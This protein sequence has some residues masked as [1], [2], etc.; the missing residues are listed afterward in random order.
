MLSL[1]STL[2]SRE[3]LQ[4]N[5]GES[6][7]HQGTHQNKDNFS[8][9]HV[10]GSHFDSVNIELPL[11]SPKAPGFSTYERES[12]GSVDEKFSEPFS[13][14]ASS[15]HDQILRGISHTTVIDVKVEDGNGM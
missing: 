9:I 4:G 2:N 3:K 12:K 10:L 14:Y 5:V 7:S 15:G 11:H 8:N 13:Q 6:G 1:L